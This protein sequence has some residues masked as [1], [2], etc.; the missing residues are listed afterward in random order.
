MGDIIPAKILKFILYTA[1]IFLLIYLLYLL[2]DLLIILAI[3]IL[4]TFIFIPFVYLLEQYGLTRFT[5]T[6]IVFVVFGLFIYLGLSIFIP[7]FVFQVNQLAESFQGYSLHD[8]LIK[9]EQEIFAYLPFFQ[10]GE[11]TGKIENFISSQIV[12]SVD[13]ITSVLSSIVSVIALLVIVPFITFF[14]LKDRRRVLQGVLHLFPNKYFEMAYWIIKKISLQLGRFVRAWIFDASFVGFTMGLGL[15]FIG[16]DNALLLGVIAGL[17]HLVPYFGPIIGG[18]PAALV[19]LLQYGD[20][21]KVPYIAILL[22]VVYT[23]DNGF[24]Q[25]YVFS[26]SVDM[27]PVVIIILIIAGSQLFGIIGMLLAVPAATVL[28]TMITEIYFAFKNYKIARL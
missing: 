9:I 20:F 7:K 23:F 21:S 14:L 26:K 28:K 6:L 19:S 16:V 11:L 10:P 2:A 24:V 22:I 13:S 8:D 1:G 18:V 3:S 15:F 5:S 17:G 12:N 27:H 25:P 4:L